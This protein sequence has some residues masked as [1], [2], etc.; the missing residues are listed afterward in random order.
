MSPKVRQ[1]RDPNTGLVL[2][3]YPF[4]DWF[5]EIL[6]GALD[7]RLLEYTGENDPK[8]GKPIYART[9]VT[10]QGLN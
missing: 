7:R 3:E 4:D 2:E 6:Q 8:T 1:I 9:T 10:L 5:G